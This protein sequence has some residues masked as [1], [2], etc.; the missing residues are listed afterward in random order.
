MMVIKWGKAGEFL[1]CPNYPECKNTSNFKRNEEGKIE[2]VVEELEMTEESCPKC[3]KPMVIRTGRYGRFLACSNYPSCKGTK[4]LT[5][6]V[7][8]PKCSEGEIAEKRSKKGKIFFGCTEYPRCDFA[9]WDRPIPENC[10][11]CGAAFLVEKTT[12]RDGATIR[13]LEKDCGYR[14]SA[15]EKD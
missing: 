13:C 15:E 6:G 3:S 7:K 5:T 4:P 8:C 14:R 11:D 1:A 9:T 12:K 2:I 10:P